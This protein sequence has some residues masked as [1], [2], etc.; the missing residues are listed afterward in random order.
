[1][2][3]AVAETENIENQKVQFPLARHGNLGLQAEGGIEA[4]A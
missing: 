3:K 1:M 4:G 2:Q